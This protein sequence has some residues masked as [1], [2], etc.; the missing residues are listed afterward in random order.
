[1]I[2]RKLN[3][4]NL[5]LAS[6]LSSGS[7]IPLTSR[8]TRL[9]TKLYYDPT[10]RIGRDEGLSPE[11][12]KYFALCYDSDLSCLLISP[13]FPPDCRENHTSILIRGDNLWE[14]FSILFVPQRAG[15]AA[16]LEIGMVFLHCWR[17]KKRW[18]RDSNPRGTEAPTGFQDRRIQ[19]LCHP[20]VYSSIVSA[21]L[22]PVNHPPRGLTYRQLQSRLRWNHRRFWCVRDEEWDIHKYESTLSWSHSMNWRHLFRSFPEYSQAE[23]KIIGHQK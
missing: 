1:M 9:N 10:R 3:I 5:Q 12:D 20:T 15:V 17:Q 23:L 16:E 13:S 21:S 2:Y 8:G 14:K 22:V 4:Y 6:A 19:P 11:M 18:G 7:F